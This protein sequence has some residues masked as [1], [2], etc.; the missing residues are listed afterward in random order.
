MDALRFFSRVDPDS[1]SFLLKKLVGYWL[2][3]LQLSLTLMLLGL[4][5]RACRLKRISTVLLAG[6][7][8][9]LILLSNKGVGIALVRPL[10]YA[11]PAQP[12][13]AGRA[14]PEEFAGCHAVVVLGGGHSDTSA[15]APTSQLSS[16]ALARL[17]EGVRLAHALPGTTLYVSG[18]SAGDGRPTHAS[19]LRQAAISLGIAPERI[20][21]ISDGHDTYGE[22]RALQKLVGDQPIALVTSAWHMPRTMMLFRRNGLSVIPCPTDYSARLNDDFRRSDYFA[23]DITG[24]ERSTKAVR[25]YLGI[26]WTFVTARQGAVEEV[27]M[28]QT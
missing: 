7:F 28:E 23:W 9:W 10:E 20:R 17:V 6:G 3:P 26:I 24:L 15:L 8:L 16:S 1:T 11:Y 4:V 13:L 25:E 5:L 27:V 21:E 14:V 22:A 19:V 18:P 2:M 12:S